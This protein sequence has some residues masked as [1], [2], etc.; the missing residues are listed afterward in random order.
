M[1]SDPCEVRLWELTRKEFRS[2]LEDGILRAAI[3]PVGSTEQH[4]E[5]LAMIFDTAAVTRVAELVAERLRPEVVVT[6]PMPVGISEH[7]MMHKGTLTFKPET[8]LAAVYDVCE[9]LVRHGL[10]N[11]LILNGHGGNDRA[12]RTI[13]PYWCDRLR[14][15]VHFASYWDTIPPGIVEQNVE[16]GRS[17][18]HAGEF[19]TSLCMA[20][21]PERIRDDDLEYD[22][23]QLATEAKGRALLEAAVEGVAG[24]AQR[25]VLSPEGA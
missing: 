25:T 18:G 14:A 6:T 9:S 5:H 21:W 8:F 17:P 22:D 15:R 12:L 2:R 11:I 10:K 1:T 23:A 13:A 19:E 3:V 20:L 7:W 24:L 4:H 16:G